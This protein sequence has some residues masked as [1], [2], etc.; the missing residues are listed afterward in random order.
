[1][2]GMRIKWGNV[3][4][5]LLVIAAAIAAFYFKDLPRNGVPIDIVDNEDWQVPE[6]TNDDIFG[7]YTMPADDEFTIGLDSW[8]G[9]TPILIGLN[10]DTTTTMIWI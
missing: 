3:I 1:M 5:F 2:Q 6:P 9:G 10:R 7:D 8:I 4:I